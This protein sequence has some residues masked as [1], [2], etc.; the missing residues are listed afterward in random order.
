MMKASLADTPDNIVTGLPVRLILGCEADTTIGRRTRPG[1]FVAEEGAPDGRRMV[2]AEV[3]DDGNEKPAPDVG[4]IIKRVTAGRGSVLAEIDWGDGSRC[5]CDCT[6]LEQA[7]EVPEAIIAERSA[8]ARNAAGSLTAAAQGNAERIAAALAAANK[9]NEELAEQVGDLS[10]RLTAL[11][12]DR[13][14]AVARG[15]AMSADP[16]R[17][18]VAAADLDAFTARTVAAATEA[19]QAAVVA[20]LKAAPAPSGLANEKEAPL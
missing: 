13:D 16:S 10:R 15:K 7:G 4:V 17:R 11:E 18:F 14:A 6:T 8:D 1:R 9:L 12:A 19:A 5:V 3:D 20:A 2:P